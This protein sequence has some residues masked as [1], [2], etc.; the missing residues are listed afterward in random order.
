MNPQEIFFYIALLILVVGAGIEFL[1]RSWLTKSA[2][3]IFLYSAFAVGAYLIYIGFAQYKVFLQGPLKPIIATWSG[4]MWF[5]G[6]VQLHFW[7]DYFVSFPFAILFLAIARYFNKKYNERF[8]EKEEP[9]LAATGILLVGYP[10]FFF[11]VPAVLLL[12]IMG[13]AIFMKPGERLPLYDFWMPTAIVVLLAI[14]F[15]AQ[16][17]VWWASFR[18]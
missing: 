2:S 7:N 8:F 10:G 9:Y 12:S 18:F 1:K 11:Y 14:H 16:N 4:F 6:Y 3:R 17:Q 15:W 13:S 5:L